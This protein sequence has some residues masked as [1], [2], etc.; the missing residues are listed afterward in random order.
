MI[1]IARRVQRLQRRLWAL[2]SGLIMTYLTLIPGLSL[3]MWGGEGHGERRG[4]RILIVTDVR[5]I[6]LAWNKGLSGWAQSFFQGF[7]SISSTHT[8]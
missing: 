4:I 5:L 3:Y 8:R 6:L 7:S 2:I 1:S